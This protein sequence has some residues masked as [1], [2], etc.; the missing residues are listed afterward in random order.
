MY[1][2]DEAGS[3]CIESLLVRLANFDTC[4]TVFD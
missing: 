2:D 1:L 3:Q 4:Y